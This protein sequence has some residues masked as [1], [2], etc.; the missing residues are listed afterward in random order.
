MPS[1]PDSDAS[2]P[3][4]LARLERAVAATPAAVRGRLARATAALRG[5]DAARAARL[6]LEATREDDG[7]LAWHVL[8]VAREQAGDFTAALA[9]YQ[10]AITRLPDDAEIANDLG[11]LA[12]RMGMTEIAEQLFRRYLAA[13]PRSVG[14]ASN[15]AAALRDLGRGGE[16]V[17]V[18]RAAISADPAQPLLWNT[19]GTILTAQGDMA[20]AIAFFDEALRVAPAMAQARYNRATAKLEL[21]DGE[22]A[23]ADCA[24]AIT[25]AATGEDRAMMAL[26]L[27]TMK[28]ADGRIGEGWDDYE[29]RLDPH[30]AGAAVFDIN[31]ARWLP[32][33]SLAGKKLLVMGEQGLG[34]EVLFASL[35]PDV[36]EAL[37]ARGRLAVA[38]EPRL[39]S[40]FQ[41]SFPTAEIL[42]HTTQ[43]QGGRNHRSAP[44]SAAEVWTPM[45]SLA[46]RFRRGLSDFPDRKA[47][48]TPDPA[49]VAHWRAELAKAPAGRKVG[50]L[51][52][53]M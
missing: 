23:I 15:L 1:D 6:A 48:L 21:G 37:G 12:A 31:L 10:S 32:R 39:V 9:A 51:W 16:A 14:A 11:R 45:A 44:P 4:A 8:A 26:A 5:G 17:E 13:H 49:R 28:L 27:A 52:K 20:G 3:S 35:L 19:L 50:I 7:A 2:D 47:F 41:R 22:A 42:P 38:V 24:Q 46:R 25:D 33:S 34:D 43:R 30:Y 18:L 36:L 29:A 53:S 40:L